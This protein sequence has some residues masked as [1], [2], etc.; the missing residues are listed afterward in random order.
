MSEIFLEKDFVSPNGSLEH[1]KVFE[2]NL[3]GEMLYKCVSEIEIFYLGLNENG[4]WVEIEMKI[5]QRSRSM[6]DLLESY[7]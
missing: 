1:L 5:T 2:I 3:G 4:E 6:G 7:S